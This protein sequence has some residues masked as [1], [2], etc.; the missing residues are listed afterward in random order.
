FMNAMLVSINRSRWFPAVLEDFQG[1][2]MTLR[3]T[4][5][6]LAPFMS[7]KADKLIRGYL[8]SESGSIIV[9][10]SVHEQKFIAGRGEHG[11]SVFLSCKINKI[12]DIETSN[13]NHIKKSTR[14]LEQLQASV[15]ALR[16][17]RLLQTV[18]AFLPYR[19]ETLGAQIYL[20]HHG[21]L[22]EL[23]GKDTVWHSEVGTTPVPAPVPT[24]VPA[25]PPPREASQ[26]QLPQRL[27]PDKARS[28]F[29]HPDPG[30][31]RTPDQIRQTLADHSKVRVEEIESLAA[32]MSWSK[33]NIDKVMVGDGHYND[34]K[35]GMTY[36]RDGRK[37][38]KRDNYRLYFKS[39]PA[40]VLCDG[41][42]KYVNILNISETGSGLGCFMD[43]D[44][45]VEPFRIGEELTLFFLL[46][47]Q[48]NLTIK[49][50]VVRSLVADDASQAPYYYYGVHF[51]WPRK[52][53][54]MNFIE[55]MQK[56][57]LFL[58]ARK[59]G[60]GEADGASITTIASRRAG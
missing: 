51:N 56:T 18:E 48:T 14:I 46:V 52:R 28:A 2:K 47:G 23:L 5:G 41:G 38:N 31:I 7:I 53:A 35:A 34:T 24:P 21:S 40:M 43:P 32:S 15:T 60:A 30:V 10:E 19:D 49:G 55:I 8:V 27:P 6:K 22:E 26:P 29:P 4:I 16:N 44:D 13:I 58:L 20:E 54:P 3:S 25:V 33:H 9:I 39:F 17:E 37:Q 36:S 59:G 1:N 50:R 45:P 11:K 57:E 12:S 42:T